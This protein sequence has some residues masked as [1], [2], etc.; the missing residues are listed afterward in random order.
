MSDEFSLFTSLRYD[1]NLEKVR[2]SGLSGKGWNYD[3]PSPFYMLDFHRDRLLRAATHWD[4]QPA[5]ERLSGD[6]GLESLT[7][8]A[9][10]AIEPSQ[11]APL[12][13]RILVSRRGEIKVE[14]FDTPKVPLENLLPTR[15]PVPSVVPS[16]NDPKKTPNYVLLVDQASTPRSEFTHFKT[17]ERAMYD[18]AQERAGISPADAKEVVIVNQSDGSVMEGTRTTPYFWRGGR[19]VTPPVAARFSWDD[20]SGGQDGT[21]RRWALEIGLA[22][23]ETVNAESLS[24]GEE[25]WVSN[26]VRGF[27]AATI[28]LRGTRT[29]GR[30]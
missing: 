10:E 5:I 18:A 4:W 3:N 11:K 13:L 25:C 2:D 16:A 27:I 29:S 20:G 7:Q 12:R 28:N 30:E 9:T 24:D 15:L 8:L 19:W 22:A 14:K 17:T 23:E 6:S 1:P 21:S 26:G